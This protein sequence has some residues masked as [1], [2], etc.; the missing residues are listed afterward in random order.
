MYYSLFVHLAVSMMLSIW[1][2][3]ANISGRKERKHK[4][5]FGKAQEKR[6]RR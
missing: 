3:E 4:S 6:E 5:K 1:K 2:V